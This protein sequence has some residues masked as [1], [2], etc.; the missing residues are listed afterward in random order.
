MRE[1]AYLSLM[2]TSIPTRLTAGLCLGYETIQKNATNASRFQTPAQIH[3]TQTIAELQYKHAI[4]SSVLCH[5]LNKDSSGHCGMMFFV[6]FS[7]C[8]RTS[9]SLGF[10]Q[11]SGIPESSFLQEHGNWKKNFFNLLQAYTKKLNYFSWKCTFYNIHFSP[12]TKK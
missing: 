10:P 11:P 9:K 2:N 4:F 8:K 12:L 7:A 3:N 5:H 6:T 1:V